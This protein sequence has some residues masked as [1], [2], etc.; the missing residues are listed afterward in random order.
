MAS[1]WVPM[2]RWSSLV[3]MVALSSACLAD[4]VTFLRIDKSVLQQ[5]LQQSPQ[6]SDQRVRVLRTMFEEAGC[7]RQ[8][9]VVQSVPGQALPNVLCTLAGTDIGTILIAARFDYDERGEEG[10]VGWGGV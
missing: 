8:S 7:P 6:G 1:G 3:V 2:L 4:N 5:R 9:V 10:A